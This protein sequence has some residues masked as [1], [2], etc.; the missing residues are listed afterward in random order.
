[1]I[2]AASQKRGNLRQ[3]L[4]SGKSRNTGIPFGEA[5]LKRSWPEFLDAHYECEA[6]G[7][8]VC[9]QD[10]LH[11]IT[12]GKVLITCPGAKKGKKDE[13]QEDDDA[14][15]RTLLELEVHVIKMWYDKKEKELVE[16]RGEGYI[17][18]RKIKAHLAPKVEGRFG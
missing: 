1:M 17:T 4:E 2:T 16:T 5:W 3:Q 6:P 18:E 9:L 12:T 10:A 8:A 14:E 11:M 7:P 15:P 13:R